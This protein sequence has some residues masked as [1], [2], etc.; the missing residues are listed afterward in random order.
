LKAALCV[1]IG[2]CLFSSLALQLA[3]KTASSGGNSYDADYVSALAAADL[4]FHAWQNHDQETG[5][6]LLSNAAKRHT[7]PEQL[8]SFFSASQPAYEITLGKK[9]KRGRYTFAVALFE[10]S[11]NR[12][13]SRRYSEIVVVRAGK[14]D[15]AIDNLP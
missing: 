11:N 15:W 14:N 2:T 4:F 10:T 9:L 1:L 13:A 12:R 6:L 8:E 7:S 5:L 3:A